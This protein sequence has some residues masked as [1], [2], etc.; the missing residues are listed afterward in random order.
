VFI[1]NAYAQ[2]ATGAA[3]GGMLQFLP[4]ILLLVAMYFLMIRP[5]MKRQKEAQIM[6]D[7]LKVGDEVIVAGGMVGTILKLKES[8]IVLELAEGVQVLAQK[9]TVATLLPKG[10]IKATLS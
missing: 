3:D 10:T 9:T 6:I 5:Q 1:S 7:G 2:S 8:Y 4:L